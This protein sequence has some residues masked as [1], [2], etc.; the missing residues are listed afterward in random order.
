MRAV[1]EEKQP[2]VLTINTIR[3]YLIFPFWREF[4]RSINQSVDKVWHYCPLGSHPFT[5]KK[6]LR[7]CQNRE[8]TLSQSLSIFRDITQ[9]VAGKTRY[10][11]EYFV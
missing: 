3:P 7:F 11:V 5:F 10:Y 1:A 8:L 6:N 4:T 2:S 9:N